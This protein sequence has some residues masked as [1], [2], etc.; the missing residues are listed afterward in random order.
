MAYMCTNF[1]VGGGGGRP[2]LGIPSQDFGPWGEGVKFSTR[3]G[4]LVKYLVRKKVELEGGGPSQ[5]RH[6]AHLWMGVKFW[7]G[8]KS[9]FKT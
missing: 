2:E 5:T 4:V 9:V 6:G 7:N 8:L 3:G 1:L